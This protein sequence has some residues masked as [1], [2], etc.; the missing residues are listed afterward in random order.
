MPAG[1]LMIHTTQDHTTQ[2]THDAHDAGQTSSAA[3]TRRMTD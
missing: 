2:D 1:G 3:S